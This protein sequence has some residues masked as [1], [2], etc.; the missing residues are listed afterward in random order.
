MTPPKSPIEAPLSPAPERMSVH[1]DRYLQVQRHLP[2]QPQRPF[3]VPIHHVL[4]RQRTRQAATAHD[5]ATA[6]AASRGPAA[7]A[8]RRGG[9][10]RHTGR[11]QG[12]QGEVDVVHL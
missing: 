3:P 2:Q 4:C 9:V 7:T 12:V 11:A 10:Q 5:A 8:H 6:G 1:H